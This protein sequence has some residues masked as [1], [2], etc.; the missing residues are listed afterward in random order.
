MSSVARQVA[1]QLGVDPVAVTQT[2][3]LSDKHGHGIW[4]ITTQEHTYILKWFPEGQSAA[5]EVQAYGLLQEL[6]VPTLPV[7]AKTNQALL[8]EDLATSAEWRLAVEDDVADPRVGEAI[9]RWYGSLHERGAELLASSQYV[10]QFLTREI[11]RL[12]QNSILSTGRLL[13]LTDHS[14]WRLAAD[15]IDL[16]KDAASNL[17]ETLN[18]NDFHWTNLALSRSVDPQLNAVVFDYHLLGIGLRYSDCRNV[19]SSLQ[20]DAVS[21]FWE[22]YGAPNA[23]EQTLD[24]PLATLVDLVI[25]TRLPEFPVWARGSRECVVRGELER[26]LVE[27]IEL[28]GGRL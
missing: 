25:A 13:G 23:R 19:T 3:T 12:D 1:E 18:Y 2:E 6:G 9:A 17:A 11:D 4:R 21:A 7:H 10:P 15:N 28:T 8:L 14:V 27:A 5:T 26:D 16:L 24:R 22:T 20:K